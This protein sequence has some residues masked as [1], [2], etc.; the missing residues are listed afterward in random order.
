MSRAEQGFTL[1]EVL[2]AVLIFAIWF[3]VIATA[4][5]QGISRESEGRLRLEASL[6]AD[7]VLADIETQVLLG[8]VPVLDGSAYSDDVFEVIIEQEPLSLSSMLGGTLP[9]A[10]AELG[11]AVPGGLQG[12]GGAAGAGGLVSQIRVDVLWGDEL[13]ALGVT[14]ITY[15]VDPVALE[16]LAANAPAQ[17]APP[18]ELEEA[19]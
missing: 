9:P 16:A 7:H 10:L 8:G 15:A 2:A 19:S 6:L 18:R 12:L 5:T 17:G 13:D 14:R 4:V 11:T 3:T 1:L